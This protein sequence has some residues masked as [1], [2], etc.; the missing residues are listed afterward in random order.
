MIIV[1]ERGLGMTTTRSRIIEEI[2]RHVSISRAEL[3][4]R[5]KFNK[6]TVSNHVQRLIE[7][8]LVLETSYDTSTGG[9]RPIL[10][11][12]NEA[13]AFAI[14]FDIERDY[15]S[16]VLLGLNGK[17]KEER[18]R[19]Y[20]PNDYPSLLE[21]ITTEIDDYIK[22]FTE[23]YGIIGV[24]ISIHGLVSNKRLIQFV[25]ETSLEDYPLYDDLKQRYPHLPIDIENNAN[26]GAIAEQSL[27]P[28][29]NAKNFLY[30]TIYSGL[31][32]GIIQ[33]NEL[34]RGSG[35]LAGEFGHTIVDVDG[36]PCICGNNGCLEQYA[37]IP[38]L[39]QSIYER[40]G[41]RLN[42]DEF[43]H[44]IEI[45]DPVVLEAVD[46]FKKYLGIGLQNLVQLFNP[47]KIIIENRI[48]SKGL[49]DI[50]N[51]SFEQ[52]HLRQTKVEFSRISEHVGAIGAALLQL[53]HFLKLHH[54]PVQTNGTNQQGAECE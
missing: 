28:N 39:I 47:D 44:A 3:S 29:L 5:T 54:F 41:N 20:Q 52:L 36:R 45:N 53:C 37:S 43:V 32:L 4:K 38:S 1:I 25:N 27:N 33:N 26:L 34:Y 31:G 30:L 8:H 6:A 16:S 19:P 7:E 49:V 40:T 11:S 50:L 35:G 2:I 17:M 15:I 18:I 23:H 22:R 9:R 51:R 10:I 14:G 48:A 12:I 24:G 21:A 42:F 46:H 13:A